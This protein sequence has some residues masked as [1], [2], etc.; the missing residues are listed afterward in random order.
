M[1]IIGTTFEDNLSGTAGNDTLD[2]VAGADTL[3]GGSGDDYYV[4]RDSRDYVS[5]SSG[6]D[7]G[8]IYTNFYK[9]TQDVEYWN[10]AFGVQKLPYWIDSMLPD[11]AAR[12]GVLLGDSHTFFYSFPN[13]APLHFRAEDAYGFIPF[14][15]QQ[16]AFVQQAFAYISSIVNLH[17]QEAPNSYGIN[18]IVLGNNLQD[19]SAGYAWY[20]SALSSG[21]DVLLDYDGNSARNLTPTQ[22]DY[23][24][25]TFI[26]ELGHAIGLKH[27]FLFGDAV[28]APY[29]PDAENNTHWTVMSYNDHPADYYLQFSPL[30]IAAL[31]YLYGPST[32]KQTNDTYSLRQD[33]PNFVW[34]GAGYDTIDGSALT[35]SMT[36]YLEPGYWGYIGSKSSLI[37]G[38]GQI[39]VNFGTVIENARGGAGDDQIVGNAA[40]NWIAGL[41]GNDIVDGGAGFD[42]A[43]FRGARSNYTIEKNAETLSVTDNMGIEGIDHLTNIERLQ[44]HDKMVVFD[45]SGTGGQA[46][47]LYQAAF[48]RAPDA[49]GLG[50]WIDY[51][52]KGASLQAAATGFFQSN[53]FK[54]LYGEHPAHADLINRFYENVLHRAPEQSGFDWWMNELSSGRQTPPSALVGF[55]ESPENQAQLIGV[56]EKGME[57]IPV[58]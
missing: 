37:S 10:W 57:Y 1:N 58:G 46:Y 14:N 7:S 15:A 13:F 9:A 19:G 8:T 38:D 56:I 36:L 28:E 11:D 30:D 55:S 20:P 35:A 21:S 43:I 39:T 18:T 33:S 2:G 25:L 45:A 47:R 52:D 40:P 48:N 49:P 51:L 5:D 24:A 12:Y 32:A 34:D 22:G 31:H 44:F 26:H 4:I 3:R 50:F 42:T 23:S 16:K 53:E 6:I 17:F 29:L 54:T 41:K 27:P